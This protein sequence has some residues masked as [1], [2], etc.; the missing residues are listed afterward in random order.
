MGKTGNISQTVFY[1]QIYAF[2]FIVQI[3]IKVFLDHYGFSN[4]LK[5][6][7]NPAKHNVAMQNGYMLNPS[8]K[9]VVGK[10]ANTTNEKF[11]VDVE[12]LLSDAFQE[13][14]LKQQMLFTQGDGSKLILN[15]NIVQYTAGN[16]AKRYLVPGAGG[17]SLTIQCDLLESKKVVGSI[18]ASKS[19]NIG[20]FG[21][22]GAW[23]KIFAEVANDVV[24]ELKSKT[25]NGNDAQVPTN[26]MANVGDSQVRVKNPSN[27]APVDTV[28]GQT[29]SNDEIARLDKLKNMKEHGLITQQEYDKKRKEILDA[30]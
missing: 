4:Y 18:N 21:A 22:I 14:L 20:A 11:D 24:I 13:K 8:S 5:S 6:N 16:A 9:I 26:K 27:N 25:A 12:Q 7:S 17:T 15:C 10:V 29:G 30:M 23:K 28:T 2:L 1:P 19:I 3:L